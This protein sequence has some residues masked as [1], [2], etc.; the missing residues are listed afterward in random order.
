MAADDN[1]AFAITVV[2]F[3]SYFEGRKGL[4]AGVVSW[5]R[6]EDDVIPGR[7]KICGAY[8][9]SVLA[10]DEA[11]H[12]GYDEAILLSRNG[13]VSEGSTCNL[14][15]MRNRKLITPPVTDNILEGITRDSVME[16]ARKELKLE[17]VE[18][19]DRPHG[20]VYVRRDLL[21]GNGGGS[22]ADSRSGPS[23][24]GKRRCWGDYGKTSRVIRRRDAWT[25]A[26][27]SAMALAGV[28][29][30]GGRKDC[31]SAHTT[32]P[33]VL[34][35]P[36]SHEIDSRFDWSRVARLFLTSRKLDDLEETKLLPEKKILYQFSARGH[37]LGQILL[38]SLLTNPHDAAS[39]YYRSRP[40]LLT[41]GLRVADALASG[42]AKSGGVSDGRDIGV[43][44]N[45]PRS[46][47][48]A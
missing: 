36:V 35:R 5:R 6:V 37:E 47:R 2:P 42:M 19:S 30:R 3:G 23:A 48:P 7:A 29:E 46:R 39:G 43:V 9:N 41:A 17:V 18:R 24:R 13:H 8:V 27:L 4:K 10:G 33:D 14:F 45:L 11:R 28:S 34:Q 38:G 40:L 22:G 12:N 25:D 31:L 21:Y 16:L 1:D 44:F 26:W 32:M 15:M 20:V